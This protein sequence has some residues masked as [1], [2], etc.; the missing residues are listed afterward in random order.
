MGKH[1]ALYC[2]RIWYQA[3]LS[4]VTGETCET[5]CAS[6]TLLGICWA[7][8]KMLAACHG[9]LRESAC[10]AEAPVGAGSLLLTCTIFECYWMIGSV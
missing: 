3:S 2:G 1:T 10:R 6:A 8:I 5:N 9:L 7:T 4:V